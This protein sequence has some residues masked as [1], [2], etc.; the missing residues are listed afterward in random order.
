MT[1]NEKGF[2]IVGV[3]AAA[4]IF[5]VVMTG[6]TQFFI[7]S[8]KSQAS[9]QSSISEANLRNMVIKSVDCTNTLKGKKIGKGTGPNFQVTELKD[10]S[11]PPEVLLSVSDFQNNL[12]VEKIRTLSTSQAKSENP[13]KISDKPE[14]VIY[15]SR[16]GSLFEAK[17]ANIKCD[18]TE[19]N[20]K[21]CHRVSCDL[22]V[23]KAGNKVDTCDFLSCTSGGIDAETLKCYN[24]DITNK[25]VLVGTCESIKGQENTFLGHKAGALKDS[26][27]RHSVFIGAHAG[28]KHREGT[29]N[30][31]IG[32]HA[33][34][35]DVSGRG[36][37][38]IGS[39]AGADNTNWHNNTFIGSS[40]GGGSK[41]G[42]NT[43]IGVVAGGGTEG[44]RNI[45]LGG[46]YV[47]EFKETLGTGGMGTWT[48][49][50]HINDTFIVSP[51]RQFGNMPFIR[52]DMRTLDEIN[53][54]KPAA[55]KEKY[56]IIEVTG[57]KDKAPER[58]AYRREVNEKLKPLETKINA[59][60]S[61]IN[62]LQSE[63]T[64]LEQRIRVL[65]TQITQ[66]PPL[67][68]PSPDSTN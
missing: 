16:P 27:G 41:G 32:A 55:D 52:G 12:K 40:A 42:F 19:A 48:H 47:S 7:I 24:V 9:I 46:R 1:L 36:N 3:L 6:T 28:S 35:S 68:V 43:Y 21:N 33:G 25:N 56:P 64:T 67:Q 53:Q 39:S 14:L 18:A 49:D 45:F 65:E 60:E 54:G 59:L 8:L 29:G 30:V 31:F 57:R 5:A 26:I 17:A 2:G 58:V 44:E 66:S 22:N 62:T 20:L 23:V 34:H 50:T 4:G 51:T 38:F 37:T 13:K 61:T 15:F 63:K 11:S 10:N